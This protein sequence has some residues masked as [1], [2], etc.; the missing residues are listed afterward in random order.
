MAATLN[1]DY[2]RLT[3][4]VEE[5]DDLSVFGLL[6]FNESEGF[7]IDKPIAFMNENITQ[8]LESLK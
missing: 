7:F 3:T 6:K 1:F 2:Q 8:G 5:G 4:T